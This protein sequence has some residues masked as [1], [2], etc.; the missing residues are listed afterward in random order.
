MTDRSMGFCCLTHLCMLKFTIIILLFIYLCV[1]EIEPSML[2]RLRM[3][4]TL[5]LHLQPPQ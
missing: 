5:E 4:L 3:G 1:L 2:H